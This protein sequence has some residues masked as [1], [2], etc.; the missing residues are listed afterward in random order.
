MFLTLLFPPKPPTPN[1]EEDLKEVLRNEAGIDLIL[2]D[3]T[4]PPEQRRKQTVGFEVFLTV[5]CSA[6]HCK[7]LWYFHALYSDKKHFSL[8]CNPWSVLLHL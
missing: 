3:N 8:S 2:E 5:K 6:V 1:L 7:R 4:P